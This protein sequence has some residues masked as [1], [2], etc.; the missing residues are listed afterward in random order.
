MTGF[1]SGEALSQLYHNAALFILP[2]SHEGMPIALLEALSHEI[3][4][5]ASDI[6]ANLALE[7]GAENYFPLGEVDALA[8]AIRRKLTTPDT[9]QS[10]ERAAQIRNSLGWNPIVDRTVEVYASALQAWK[11]RTAHRGAADAKRPLGFG[12]PP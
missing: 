3:P 1:Q 9:A 11:P 4:C 10:Q 5:L 8:D 2:S 6:S 12:N 7:L